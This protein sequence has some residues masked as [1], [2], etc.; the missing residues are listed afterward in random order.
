M[1]TVEASGRCVTNLHTE[2]YDNPQIWGRR[3]EELS[4]AVVER[5]RASLDLIAPDT[6]TI[7]DVGCGD[8]MITNELA[9]LYKVVGLD[10]SAEALKHVE[11][12]TYQGTLEG[13]PFAPQSF[14]VVTAFEVLEHLPLREYDIARSRMAELTRRYIVITVPYKE[15]P[16][17]DFTRCPVC[18]TT[19]NVW[20]H[21]RQFDEKVLETLFP[22]MRLIR[23]E[24]IGPRVKR[25]HPLI[26]YIRLN[27]LCAWKPTERAVCP[28]CG[29]RS[30]PYKFG[31]RHYATGALRRLSAILWPFDKGARWAGAVYEHAE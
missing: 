21:L 18:G 14:D 4:A 31:L 1:L 23:F 13:A 25:S 29:N 19:F 5:V 2:Y 8:G 26:L 28:Q 15:P 24:P 7:L 11:A 12:E 10:I 27:L 30:F 16:K 3:P 6:G 17:T 9:R 20:C 22:G